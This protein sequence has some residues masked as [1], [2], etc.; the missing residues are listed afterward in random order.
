MPGRTKWT[1]GRSA[2]GGDMSGP[3]FHFDFGSPN[4]Y[5]AH[6]VIPEIEQRTGGEIRLCTGVAGRRLQADRQSLAGGGVRRDKEQAGIRAPRNRAVS[7]AP[8][9]HQLPAQPVL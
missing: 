5:L 9:D 1:C 7:A 6:R 8:W 3:E 2:K 4:A